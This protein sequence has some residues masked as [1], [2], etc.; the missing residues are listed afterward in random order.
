MDILR[1]EPKVYDYVEIEEDDEDIQESDH[2]GRYSDDEDL[3]SE[4][5]DDDDDGDS[6]SD[7]S[8]KSSK[9]DISK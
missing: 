9:S 7:G 3:E 5:G 6:D 2:G 8:D 1:E 4:E